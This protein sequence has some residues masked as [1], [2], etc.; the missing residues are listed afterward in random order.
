M[1]P[2]I[3]AVFPNEVNYKWPQNWNNCS[4]RKGIILYKLARAFIRFVLYFKARRDLCN[5]A[6]VRETLAD[7][8]KTRPVHDFYVRYY[9]QWHGGDTDWWWHIV[10]LCGFSLKLWTHCLLCVCLCEQEKPS[11]RTAHYKLTSTVMLWLQT[12]KAGSGT[13]NLGGSLTR[14]VWCQTE[15]IHVQTCCSHPW[16][17]FV[18]SFHRWKKMRQSEKAHPTSPTLAALS[19]SVWWLISCSFNILTTYVKQ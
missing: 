3:K 16:T 6:G 2:G 13:M 4:E 12:T 1:W 11:G 17:R 14:Q 18:L 19:K 15:P 7:E 9:H 10:K 8:N 5:P